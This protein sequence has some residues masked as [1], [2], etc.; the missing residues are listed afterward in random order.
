MLFPLLQELAMQ[1]TSYHDDHL[2]Q[3]VDYNP[4]LEWIVLGVMGL[5]LVGMLVGAGF[6][7]ALK[8]L[9]FQSM[10]LVF[11]VL[12]L[13]HGIYMMGWRRGCTFF[14]VA[15][16]VGFVMEYLGV[17]T[18]VIFGHYHYTD[19]LNPKILG[20]VPVV[21]PLAWFMVLYLSHQMANL[22][23]TGRSV[24]G[25]KGA[26]ATFFAALL[27]GMI[28][29][30]WDLVMDPVMVSDVGAWVWERGGG[31]Y[32]IPMRNFLGW[33]V[34][35]ALASGIYRMLEPHLEMRPLGRTRPL[36]LVLPMIGYGVLCLG[37]LVIGNPPATRAVAPFAMG[38][39]LMAAMLKLY[40]GN[41]PDRCIGA[42]K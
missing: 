42:P 4:V 23:L 3:D 28:L 17:K 1:W 30:A 41:H 7:I 34:T 19:V 29:T 20:T 31:Y 35:G 39:P 8:D 9:P 24:G 15:V 5:L 13:I 2:N 36:F 27:S 14:G 10:T 6:R 16:V 38:I 18:G 12:V 33:V 11:S 22:L 26:W 40:G 37:D 25:P 21:I 32:G